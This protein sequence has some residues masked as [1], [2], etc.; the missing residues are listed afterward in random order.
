AAVCTD[1]PSN[2]HPTAPTARA[3][4][5]PS[6]ARDAAPERAA[7]R[8]RCSAGRTSWYLRKL[9]SIAGGLFS[10]W[11]ASSGVSRAMD[12]ARRRASSPRRIDKASRTRAACSVSRTP[13][14]CHPRTQ[15]RFCVSQHGHPHTC[16]AAS[17]SQAVR[18]SPSPPLL[19][20]AAACPPALRSSCIEE[21]GR[22][23]GAAPGVTPP[24]VDEAWSWFARRPRDTRRLPASSIALAHS[25]TRPPSHAPLATT[26]ASQRA[27]PALHPA[28]SPRP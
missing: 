27:S 23:P 11:R 1:R 12:L 16:T 10:T 14:S 20:R 18:P 8:K 17:T 7:S 2:T 28:W 19:P 24:G 21:A 15:S 9:A 5:P 26:H 6:S 22:F 13:P 25:R 3:N 4:S